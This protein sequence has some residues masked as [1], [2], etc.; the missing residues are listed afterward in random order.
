MFYLVNQDARKLKC[1]PLRCTF[2][3][4]STLSKL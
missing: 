1:P 4:R 2:C 3:R